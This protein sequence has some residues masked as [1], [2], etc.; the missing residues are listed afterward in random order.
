MGRTV[1]L[2]EDEL[3]RLTASGRVGPYTGV[4]VGQVGFELGCVPIL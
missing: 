2:E 4:L 1:A 3:N